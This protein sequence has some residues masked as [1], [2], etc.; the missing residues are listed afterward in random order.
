MTKVGGIK[1]AIAFEQGVTLG[2]SSASTAGRRDHALYLVRRQVFTAAAGVI[3]PADGRFPFALCSK[4]RLG[5]LN[6]YAHSP[7]SI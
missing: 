7:C 6:H 3:C 1:R 2:E 5:K 4:W